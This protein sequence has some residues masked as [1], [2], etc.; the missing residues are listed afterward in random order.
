MQP[1][2]GMAGGIELGG[3]LSLVT[4]IFVIVAFWFLFTG[5]WDRLV[6]TVIG[7]VALAGVVTAVVA[8][9]AEAAGSMWTFVLDLTGIG[10]G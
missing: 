8:N 5:R 6:L 9:P 7:F 4:L 2:Q 1:E 10:G 3:V